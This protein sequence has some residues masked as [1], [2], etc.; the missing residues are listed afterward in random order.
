MMKLIYFLFFVYFG[1]QKS[2]DLSNFGMLS[3]STETEQYSQFNMLSKKLE[4]ME[5]VVH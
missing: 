2:L 5:I 3:V 4:M 1:W